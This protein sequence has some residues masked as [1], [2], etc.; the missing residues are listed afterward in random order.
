[1]NSDEPTSLS[2]RTCCVFLSITPLNFSP[3]L[4]LS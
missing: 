2:V 1:M 3:L 4:Q